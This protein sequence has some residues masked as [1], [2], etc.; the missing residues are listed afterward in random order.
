M[1]TQQNTL[2][3]CLLPNAHCQASGRGWAMGIGHWAMGWRPGAAAAVVLASLAP[4]AAHAE[5]IRFDALSLELRPGERAAVLVLLDESVTPLF[6]YSLDIELDGPAGADGLSINPDQTSFFDAQNL[7]TAGGEARDPLFSVIR[8]TPG[9]GAFI[10]T[11]SESGN[12]LLAEPGVND[13]L[14]EL[15]FDA[16][17]GGLGRYEITFGAGTALSTALGDPVPFTPTALSITAIPA[18]AAIAVLCGGG[19]A[20]CPRARQRRR[21]Q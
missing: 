9:G 17:S 11:N 10:S 3:H 1:R 18:P 14:A 19:L 12:E 7:F 20:L 5:V 13:V 16:G 6:G 21:G 4:H 2:A 15:V 8:G